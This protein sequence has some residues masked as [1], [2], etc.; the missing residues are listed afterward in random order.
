MLWAISASF[1]L[2]GPVVRKL[3]ETVCGAHPGPR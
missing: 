2:S 1:A 3:T